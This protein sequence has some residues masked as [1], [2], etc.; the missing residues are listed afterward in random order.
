LWQ[1]CNWFYLLTQFCDIF[2]KKLFFCHNNRFS[3]F[4]PF[5][6]RNFGTGW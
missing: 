4:K 6:S 5:D 2:F 1:F 3:I